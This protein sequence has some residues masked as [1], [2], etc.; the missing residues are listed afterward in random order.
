[1]LTRI[2]WE[3]LKLLFPRPTFNSPVSFFSKDC[4]NRVFLADDWWWVRLAVNSGHSPSDPRVPFLFCWWPF[5]SITALAAS[6]IC[7]H[8]SHAGSSTRYS[9]E[10]D[11][12][13][14]DIEGKSL[15]DSHHPRLIGPSDV[16]EKH[17]RN[18]HC[19]SNMKQAGDGS[20]LVHVWGLGHNCLPLRKRYE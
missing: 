1:M 4:D 12:M 16:I 2:K 5:L 18:L 8:D 19:D 17:M 6:L 11:W 7:S 14:A 20:E 15:I 9:T 10:K 3:I 13:I